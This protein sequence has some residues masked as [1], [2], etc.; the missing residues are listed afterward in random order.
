MYRPSIGL[1]GA[2]AVTLWMVPELAAQA[3]P[4]L[5]TTSSTTTTTGSSTSSSTPAPGA[6][7]VD[8]SQ[9]NWRFGQVSPYAQQPI[10][11]S[12][13]TQ[14][15]ATAPSTV[16]NS[17]NIYVG[18]ALAN[19]GSLITS[20]ST[21][22]ATTTPTVPAAI[23]GSSS[24]LGST[25]YVS[26]FVSFE[27]LTPSYGVTPT[28]TNP[29]IESLPNLNTFSPSL[30]TFAVPEPTTWIL[31]GGVLVLVGYG[32]SRRQLKAEATAEEKPTGEANE[33]VS[34]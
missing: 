20:G 22:T 11:G 23:N 34:V 21:G 30:S 16:P 10:A 25:N 5:P 8:L 28:I 13:T 27:S 32:Y 9:M 14:T 15:T 4:F 2:F 29:P 31:C 26:R 1:V 7:P 24:T 17:N 6:S 33:A 19:Q 18:S 12:A 3:V